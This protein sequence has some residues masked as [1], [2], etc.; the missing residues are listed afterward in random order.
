MCAVVLL[1][2]D[3]VEDSRPLERMLAL[4]G[5][6][7]V[8]DLTEKLNGNYDAHRV[9]VSNV[10]LSSKT[11]IEATKTALRRFRKRGMPFVCLLQDQSRRAVIQAHALG[12]TRILP[13]TAPATEILRHISQI[14][15]GDDDSDT[16][17]DGP[18]KVQEHFVAATAALADMLDAAEHGRA[19]PLKTINDSVD[20]INRAADAADLGAWLDVVWNHDDLTYQH[21]LL[22][23]GLAAA[24]A[25][26]LGFSTDDRRLLT[27][28]A[29]LHDVGKAKIP[30]DILHKKGPLTPAEWDMIRTH[31][32]LGYEMLLEPGHFTGDI[33]DAARDHHEYLDGS[34]YPNGLRGDQIS[35]VVRMITICDIYAALIER[36]SYKPPMPA[37]AA[38]DV[39]LEMGGKLDADLVRVFRRIVL[40]DA[41]A[42]PARGSRAADDSAAAAV[43]P[44]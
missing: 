25:R 22:V 42:Q 8:V 40:D 35:D 2:T 24:F 34:G 15:D 21:C 6:C 23:A 3:R 28:A 27:G 30:L 11:A 36:R 31:P 38:Y 1:I 18:A 14:L 44:G 19:L 37:E 41:G 16:E 13:A 4:W 17:S 7:I 12:A 5:P 39:L 43:M 29:V 9:V 10:E 32:R 26:Q 20:S 33:L